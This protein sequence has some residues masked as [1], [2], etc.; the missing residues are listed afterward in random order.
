MDIEVVARVLRNTEGDTEGGCW[1]CVVVEVVVIVH[2]TSVCGVLLKS[3]IDNLKP[4]VLANLK[5]AM[6]YVR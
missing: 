4:T 5:S 2:E 1:G 6:M 3:T